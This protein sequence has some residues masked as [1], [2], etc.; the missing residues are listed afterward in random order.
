MFL[1]G[2][3]GVLDV[4]YCYGFRINN[5]TFLAPVATRIATRDPGLTDQTCC[6]RIL[7]P[8]KRE[9]K[10]N[11]GPA[12]PPAEER[13]YAEDVRGIENVFGKVFPGF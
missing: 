2:F 12:P 6:G 1:Q 4:K 13:E 3:Q 11:A 10:F 8:H 7:L 9:L 5:I